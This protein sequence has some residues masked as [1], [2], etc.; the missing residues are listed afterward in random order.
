M[1]RQDRGWTSSALTGHPARMRE[2]G[3]E[4]LSGAARPH[5]APDAVPSA[6]GSDA[7]GSGSE[8]SGSGSDATVPASSADPG[9]RAEP[10]TPGH[11]VRWPV[12]ATRDS[13]LLLAARLTGQASDGLLQAALGS[14]VLFSPERQA[15]ATQ[16]AMTFAILLLPYS[17][18]G[19]FAG[20]LLDRWSRTRVIV[21]ANIAR[22]GVMVGV[23]MM[24]AAGRDGFDLGSTVLIAM[25]LG[26][27]VLAG[28]SAGLPHVVAP[29]HLVTANALFPTAGTVAGAIA[30]VIGLVL[31]PRLGD[32]AAQQLVL[33]VAGLLLAA[34]VVASRIGVRDLGPD[35]TETA[36]GSTLTH[37]LMAVVRGMVDGLRHLHHRPRARRAMAVVVLHRVAF[38]AMLVDALL[39]VRHTL[40]APAETDA[41][42]ADFALT[43]AGASL[44]SFAAAFAAPPLSRRIGL[45]TWAAASLAIAAVVGPVG[46]STLWLP[47]IVLGS[48]TLGFAGQTVKISGDTWLQR[49]V[50]DDFRGRVFSVYDVVLNIGLVSGICVAAFSAPDSGVAV[51]LWV[52]VSVLLLATALWSLRPTRARG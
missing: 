1:Q 26:R 27:L 20:V 29:A 49:D 38:G 31:A 39:I 10:A 46:V 52:G 24:V 45:T 12:I 22:A 34:A 37:D 3:E 13:R 33:V 14:F 5:G 19:P 28:L 9:M 6:P 44:G 18:V 21:V 25:G 48:F 47:A 4:N 42:L 40:N 15:S 30:T 51:G 35:P 41:A 7:S 36:S 50:D 23:A 2:G 16:V 32:D 8:A 17:L 43:A 11:P